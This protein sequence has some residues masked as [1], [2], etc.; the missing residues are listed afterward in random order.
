MHQSIGL[1]LTTLK[2]L[3]YKIGLICLTLFP[4]FHLCYY[5][6]LMDLLRILHVSK[7]LT[8]RALLPIFLLHMFF[9]FCRMERMLFNLLIELSQ[10]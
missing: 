3:E 4:H 2:K 8:G 6:V 1:L 9:F 10:P 7:L 5:L